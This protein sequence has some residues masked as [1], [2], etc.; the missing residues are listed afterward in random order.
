MISTDNDHIEAEKAQFSKETKWQELPKIH[1]YWSN[2][3]LAPKM[4]EVYGGLGMPYFFSKG[5]VY[6]RSKK[7]K[8]RILSIGSGLCKVE[9]KIGV[10]L[11]ELGFTDV[12]IECLEMSPERCEAARNR[13][14]RDGVSDIISVTEVSINDW[15]PCKHYTSV[16]ANHSLHHFTNLED[17][18]QIIV[19]IMDDNGQFVVN[20][21]IGRNGHQRWSE[22]LEYLTAIWRIIPRKYKLDRHEGKYYDVYENIDYSIRTNEG[23]R[24]QDILPLL[25]RSFKATRFVAEGGLIDI[26]V[27]RKFGHNFDI[28][29]QEDKALIDQIAFMNT[30]LIEA[31]IIKP[32]MML[33]WF[34]KS[35]VFVES[36]KIHGNWS[37]EFC[38]RDPRV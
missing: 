26:F 6:G 5:L 28:N 7:E 9:Q 25:N 33:A 36:A 20:D 16:M 2:R 17:I 35:N 38:T 19:E 37:Q 14:L 11:N 21:M 8:I 29:T 30:T 22:V 12:H 18:F 31:G 3:Y 32:T 23:I 27:D 24:A 34:R 10:L 1:G 4:K 15:N 13:F